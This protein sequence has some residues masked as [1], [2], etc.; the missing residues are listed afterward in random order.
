MQKQNISANAT[1][2]VQ[3]NS[4]MGEWVRTIVDVRKG[5]LSSHTFFNIFLERIMSVALEEH[6]GQVNIGGRNITNL[7]FADD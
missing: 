5:Y 2:A 1:V 4:N 6:D 7:R 3:M